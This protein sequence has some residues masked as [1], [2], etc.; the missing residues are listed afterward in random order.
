M[1]EKFSKVLVSLMIAGQ[2]SIFPAKSLASELK[3]F[4]NYSEQNNSM[5]V[6]KKQPKFSSVAEVKKA[7]DF[8]MVQKD[9]KIPKKMYKYSNYQKGQ[10]TAHMLFNFYQMS[11]KERAES[12]KGKKTYNILA[13]LYYSRDDKGFQDGF[14]N[15]VTAKLEKENP[16]AYMNFVSL[17]EEFDSYY[18]GEIDEGRTP[19]ALLNYLLEGYDQKEAA[20]LVP[21]PAKTMSLLAVITD[22]TLHDFI[23]E[24]SDEYSELP[25]EEAVEL[26]VKSFRYDFDTSEENAKMILKAILYTYSS[27]E[28]NDRKMFIKW[29]KKINEKERMTLLKEVEK[30]TYMKKTTLPT[31]V[32]KEMFQNVKLQKSEKKKLEE[33]MEKEIEGYPGYIKDG[34][35]KKFTKALGWTP[36]SYYLERVMKRLEYIEKKIEYL[37]FKDKPKPKEKEELKQLQNEI[38]TLEKWLKQFKLSTLTPSS[39]LKELQ[40]GMLAVQKE[41]VLLSMDNMALVPLITQTEPSELREFYLFTLIGIDAVSGRLFTDI[42]TTGDIEKQMYDIVKNKLS[43]KNVSSAWETW[44]SQY[45]ETNVPL[46]QGDQMTNLLYEYM[47][48]HEGNK[49]PMLMIAFQDYYTQ[50]VSSGVTSPEEKELILNTSMKLTAMHPLLAVKY[51]NAMRHIAELCK[52]NPDVYLQAAVAISARVDAASTSAFSSKTGFQMGA[53][54]MRKIVNNLSSGFD[55]I[56]NIEEGSLAQYN[57][58]DIV[59]NNLYV[60]G[61]TN[62]ITQKPPG[63]VPQINQG[64]EQVQKYLV[65]SP[66]PHYLYTTPYGTPFSGG[67]L[68]VNQQSYEGTLMMPQ[69]QP[70]WVPSGAQQALNAV[71]NYLFEDHPIVGIGEHLPGTN[72]NGLTAT[73]LLKEINSAFVHTEPLD[74]ESALIGGGG[75]IGASGKHA[76]NQPDEASIMGLGTFLTPTGGAA[77]GGNYTYPGHDAFAGGNAVAM[78]MGTIKKGVAKGTELGMESFA[79]GFENIEGG[80]QRLLMESI[81]NAW[82]QDN[83]SDIFINVNYQKTAKINGES[84]AWMTSRLFYVDKNGTVFELK[85][86][87]SDFIDMFNFAAGSFDEAFNTP[88]LGIWNVEPTI[89]T[90]GQKKTKGKGGSAIAFD[91]G[92]TSWL[93][94]FQSV[95]FMTQDAKAGMSQYNDLINAAQDELEAKREELSQAEDDLAI[96][97][98]AGDTVE[99]DRLRWIIGDDTAGSE[100]GLHQDIVLLETNITDL[101]QQKQMYHVNEVQ[102]PL[103]LQWTPGVAWTKEKKEKDK[104]NI[105]E[106]T[107][108]GQLLKMEETEAGAEAESQYVAQDVKF[109]VRQ[110]EGENATELTIGMGVGE[111]KKLWI[112]EG[113]DIEGLKEYF[114]RGGFF[115]KSQS[116]KVSWGI[117]SYYEGTPDLQSIAM[118][119]DSEEARN[120]IESLHKIGLTLYGKG[121]VANNLFLGGLGHFMEQLR[122]Y[123]T[124]EGNKKWDTQ[125]FYKLVGF[126][127]GVDNVMKIEALRVSGFEQMLAD[128]EGLMQDAQK[129]PQNAQTFISQ[130]HDKYE[131]MITQVFDEYYLGVQLDKDFSLEAKL[132]FKE[133]EQD[134]TKQIPENIQA[135]ALATWDSGFWRIYASI[136][137]WL[138]AAVEST[139]AEGSLAERVGLVG[140]GFGF[141]VFNGYFLQRIAFDAGAILAFDEVA[142][143]E[144]PGLEEKNFKKPGA[145]AQAALMLYSD[146][147]PMSKQYRKLVNNYEKYDEA[148][149]KGDFSKINTNV[150]DTMCDGIN[151]DII[152][153]EVLKK[154]R[155]GKDVILTEMQTEA[156]SDSL[157]QWFYDE[158]TV[159]EEK[160]NGKVNTYLAGDMYL[161]NKDKIHW[162]IGFFFEYVD[163]VKAYVILAEREKMGLYTGVDIQIQPEVVLSAVTSVTL[164]KEPEASAGLSMKVKAGPGWFS[165]HFY[166]KTG[167]PPVYSHPAYVPYEHFGDELEWSLMF[168][169]TIGF[170]GGAPVQFNPTH[171]PSVAPK[172]WWQSY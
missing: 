108:P 71:E 89:E 43:E 136:P 157:W 15:E 105:Y 127:K 165:T 123:E 172:P 61:F 41:Y 70:M 37:E 64:K 46:G 47:G 48:G 99:E 9:K 160:F 16:D 75:A 141:D 12:E 6:M 60:D 53:P 147:L 161:Y 104:T 101:E 57:K 163:A 151:E 110:I 117:G 114:G 112:D 5:P 4:K 148:V 109:M 115:Y 126:M 118:L 13:E 84:K 164:E 121:D 103:L 39:Q 17:F 156:L 92:K 3:T 35:M 134:W 98:A 91:A 14:S 38:K 86:G 11:P 25:R 56:L 138:P 133:E 21:K 132:V 153:P 58:Y 166:L 24:F 33:E 129:N 146:V 107:F 2:L 10:L 30:T 42:D 90:A 142:S 19:V 145:F 62:V 49:S 97:I 52:G 139:S 106:L 78:P 22:Q 95:P 119:E 67:T 73:E 168:Y 125:T 128:Y 170:G 55:A 130:F 143:E 140:T 7:I 29:F 131:Y 167:A 32:V 85:G 63:Y 135:K 36:N 68:G 149:E 54:N 65:P 45:Y 50:A 144:I 23:K 83:P 120:Y 154:I 20:G 155:N 44:Y 77:F 28:G 26:L 72:I 158:K 171:S 137:T 18:Q 59:D 102:Q 79:G 51:F 34:S 159:L 69:I 94:H 81:I 8:L 96:A 116:P 27:L 124:E 169:Y 150:L 40:E 66:F 74:Y 93:F 31:A 152:S 111:A 100:T 80:A 82:D 87:K 113:G 88:V 76:S 162:D 122:P 1:G